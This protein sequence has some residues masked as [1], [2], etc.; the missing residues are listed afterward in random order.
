MRRT[1]VLWFALV[2]LASSIVSC[3]S[4]PTTTSTPTVAPTSTTVPLE[5]TI[6]FEKNCW[7]GDVYAWIDENADGVW[8][9]G[10]TA[11]PGVALNLTGPGVSHTDVSDEDGRAELGACWTVR[12]SRE[13]QSSVCV[14]IDPDPERKLEVYPTVPPSYRLTTV[15]R[16]RT[17]LGGPLQFGF[18]LNGPTPTPHGGG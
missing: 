11:F 10:E 14:A 7:R 12:C 16:R 9:E 18:V 15:A 5:V 8:D 4:V 1:G 17:R 13:P 6:E 3:K 2:S